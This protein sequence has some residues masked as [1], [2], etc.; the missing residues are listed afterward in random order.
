MSNGGERK[1]LGKGLSAL[2]SEA[3]VSFVNSQS[4]RQI[5]LLPLS[6]ISFNPN[7]PRKTF[8]HEELEELTNS[9]KEYGI[10]QPIIVR[11]V[12]N[13]QY[14]IVAGERRYHAAK[15]AGLTDISV[16]IK[17]IN[18]IDS[19]EIALI[20]NIQRQ[21]LNILEEAEAY[22]RLID[23][24]SHTQESLAQ[25][26][27]K[28]RSYIANTVRLLRLPEEIKQLVA[29]QKISSGH[30]RAIVNT[31]NPIEFARSI[32]ENNLNVRETEKLIKRMQAK[33]QTAGKNDE[34]RQDRGAQEQNV[35]I[36]LLERSLSN[37]LRAKVRI[38]IDDAHCKITIHCSDLEE[39]DAIIAK[40][41]STGV[42][43]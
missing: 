34:K 12:D 16:I 17:N 15:K 40:L 11:R 18:E 19:F 30:A 32:M 37:N 31:D 25:K 2:I 43:L 6:S 33:G 13:E 20:E 4:D 26:M 23:E 5:F 22:R 21:N 8:G 1:I 14:Q 41:G 42:D 38:N 7:Q 39:F 27:G 3:T 28:S 9:I 24:Y 36:K 29:D 35:D 10:L